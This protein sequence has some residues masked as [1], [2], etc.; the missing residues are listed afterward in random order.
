MPT[1]S[2]R[3]KEER[4][5]RS[6]LQFA[7]QP[8]LSLE[9]MTLTDIFIVYFT[10]GAPLAVYKYLQNRSLNRSRRILY[11]LATFIFWVPAAVQI[12]YLYLRNAYS[13]DAFVSKQ[14]L[15]VREKLLLKTGE[16][17]RI[18]V[19]GYVRAARL[20]DVR[21][22]IDRYIGL[23]SAVRDGA[24]ATAIG[25]EFFDAAGRRK[26]DLAQRCLMRRNLRRLELHHT[27]ARRDL[28]DLLEEA[29]ERFDVSPAVRI[30]IELA[31]QL[32]DAK[33]VRNLRGLIAQWGEVW[34]SKLKDRPT[35]V[36]SVPPIVMTAASLN[37]D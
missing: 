10:F 5:H 32:D 31:T 12:V 36:T 3:S 30:A 21:E 6:D 37:N 27:Q 33:T 20:H 1:T 17:L 22:T 26:H 29:S 13:G 34:D 24:T 16:L 9:T 15:D 11:S 2:G 8:L 28:F 19:I 4:G 18:E 25:S 14:D 35:T 23:A 7:V